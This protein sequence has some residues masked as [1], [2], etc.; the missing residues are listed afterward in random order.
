MDITLD[1]RPS[2]YRESLNLLVQMFRFAHSIFYIS[3][4]TIE[5]CKIIMSIFLLLKLLVTV[6][7][8]METCIL[9][10]HIY[11]CVF[12]Q[13]TFNIHIVVFSFLLVVVSSL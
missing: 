7:N 13:Y 12:S 5:Y 3:V 1:N 11:I 8:N 9:H 2:M 10:T 6:V 4:K